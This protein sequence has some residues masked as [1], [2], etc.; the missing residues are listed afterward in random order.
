MALAR[1][2]FIH[3]RLEGVARLS[4]SK[5]L[6]LGVFGLGASQP[7]EILPRDSRQ[8]GY[9]ASA[10]FMGLNVVQMTSPGDMN[11]CYD[12]VTNQK[13]A[14]IYLPDYGLEVGKK[15]SLVVLDA[16]NPIEAIRL[17]P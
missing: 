11:R 7:I 17:R 14:I 8:H 15:A 6:I 12:R 16:G 9:G 5:F 4:G 2:A 1:C 10:A 13:A 3:G